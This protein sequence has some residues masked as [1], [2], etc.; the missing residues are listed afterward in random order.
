MKKVVL[1]L[2]AIAFV[3]TGCGPSD[4]EVAAMVHGFVAQTVEAFTPIPS[5]TPYQTYTPADTAT[6]YPTYTPQDTP[7]TQVETKI[8]V[9]TVTNT[10]TPLYTPTI[11]ETPTLTVPPTNTAAPTGTKDPT[12]LDKGA[13]F[14]L[15]TDDIAPGVWRS[16]GTTDTC[17]W[18]ITR[19]DGGIVSNHFG[20]AGGTMYI[21]TSAFQVQMKSEC[22]TWTY[23]GAP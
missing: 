8:V 23:I 13:G 22:G 11:T 5:N 3:L 17:Y 2:I 16:D 7:T 10:A 18:E 6:P 14:Y 19:K 21:P 9:V 15:V 12:Q 20:M 4:Q 1:A